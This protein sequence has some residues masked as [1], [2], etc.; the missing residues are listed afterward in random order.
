MTFTDS[1][2]VEQ[3]ILDAAKF[4]G[5]QVSMVRE[6]APPYEGEL[7]GDEYAQRA[8]QSGQRLRGLCTKSAFCTQSWKSAQKVG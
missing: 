6:D 4:S 3:M 2:T 7:L 1:N 8:G 5:R